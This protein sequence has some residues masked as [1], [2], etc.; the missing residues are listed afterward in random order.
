M[1]CE[2]CRIARQALIEELD[3]LELELDGLMRNQ[4]DGA[5]RT[6]KGSLRMLELSEQ[7]DNLYYRLLQED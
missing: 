3:S 4:R 5:N 6:R 7:I 2:E 1:Y